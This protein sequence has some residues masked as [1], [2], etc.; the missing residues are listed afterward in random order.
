ML[1]E[2]CTDTL[3]SS[4]IAQQAGANRIELCADLCVGGTTPSAGLIRLVKEKLDIPIAVMIRPRSG[5]FC[6]SEDE[7]DTMKANIKFAKDSGVESVVFG[8]LTPEGQI[9]IPK[10]T[11]LIAQAKPMKVTCHR[12]FDMTK[13]PIESLDI[14]IDL[15][16]DRLLTG[17][18]SNTAFDG[19]ETLKMLNEKSRGQITIM[20][21]SGINV[22]NITKLISNT[23]ITEFHLSGK[24][25]KDS[26]MIFRKT[27]ISMGAASGDNEY[28]IEQAS[29]KTIKSVADLL[30]T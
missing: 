21:G 27:A 15:G 7:L 25:K 19:I 11:E 13:N 26:Q 9:N 12:A 20:A 1:L 14:L 17:G 2:I 30:K 24:T 4:V 16:V 29:F 5:D 3:A 8:V 18:F 22:D 6:Y 10:M 23:G 28:L